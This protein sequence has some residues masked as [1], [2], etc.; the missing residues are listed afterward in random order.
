MRRIKLQGV[1]LSLIL[2]MG[3]Y[4]ATMIWVES[5]N[6]TFSIFHTLGP[7]LFV[8]T[9]ASCCSYVLRYIRWRWLFF[10]AGVQ[11]EAWRGFVSYLAGFAFTV[12][13]GKFGE[14][15]RIRYLAQMGV[16][17]Q[18]TL[19]AFIYERAFD[20]MVVLALASFL[21][22]KT[23][24]F[25]AVAVF[26]I[27]AVLLLALCA[28]N[29]IFLGKTMAYFWS[30]KIRKLSR[31][32]RTLR[33]GLVGCKFWLNPLDLIFCFVF[34]VVAWGITALSFLYLCRHIEITIP[35]FEQFSI[36]PIS[37][38][39]GAASMIPG[40]LG[41]TEATIIT[42]LTSSGARLDLAVL[43]AAG[44]R[45]ATLWFSMLLGIFSIIYLEINK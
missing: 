32:I 17:P 6:Q 9:L 43:A 39:A 24:F 1:F 18:L 14:L 11:I 37:I 26:A 8:V 20:L 22:G 12:T 38:L 29:P 7:T 19:A 16:S 2:I 10:R 13:P 21:F 25:I 31:I 28:S 40:G 33:D 23:D 41:S 42:L 5:Q 4:L 44:V 3:L 30:L 35:F 27:G 45:L 36:Y 15:V 34:G